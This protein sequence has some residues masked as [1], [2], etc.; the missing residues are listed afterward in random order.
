MGPLA[1]CS[2]ETGLAAAGPEWL[3]TGS[4]SSRLTV[5]PPPGRP[6]RVM[7]SAP[8]ASRQAVKEQA[9]AS[10][11]PSLDTATP[12]AVSAAAA[13]PPIKNWDGYSDVNDPLR[14]SLS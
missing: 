13:M 3:V 1:D 4:S 8:A 12:S 7:A 10:A 5:A 11:R 14:S 9:K 2:S 6:N